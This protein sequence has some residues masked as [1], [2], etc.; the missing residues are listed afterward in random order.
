M[1]KKVLHLEI[2]SFL[3]VWVLFIISHTHT[4]GYTIHIIAYFLLYI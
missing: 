2:G 1:L 3:L 4:G